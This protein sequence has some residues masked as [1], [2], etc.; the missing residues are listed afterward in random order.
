MQ[1]HI[2]YYI[3]NTARAAQITFAE[4]IINQHVVINEGAFSTAAER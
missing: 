1:V 4:W 3:Y 2:F